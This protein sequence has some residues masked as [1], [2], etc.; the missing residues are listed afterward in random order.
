MLHP[1]SRENEDKSLG[2]K[3][4]EPS[5]RRRK[6]SRKKRRRGKRAESKAVRKKHKA[7]R[8]RSRLDK[9]TFDMFNVR[10]AAVD[11]ANGIGHIDPLLRSCAA[12]GCGVI[13]L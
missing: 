8:A 11:G 12:K 6:F 4:L 1:T 13:R 3:H 9:L 10:T 2:K 5:E 7:A